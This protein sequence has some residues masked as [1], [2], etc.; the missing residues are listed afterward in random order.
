MLV[1]TKITKFTYQRYQIYLNEELAFVLYK[2]EVKRYDLEVGINISAERIK[3]IESEVLLPRSKKK[4]LHILERSDRSENELRQKLKSCFYPQ[5]IIDAT[6]MYVKSF[7]YIDDMN[8]C[9]KFIESRGNHKSKKDLQYTLLH[10]GVDRTLIDEVLSSL[11]TE[12]DSECAIEQLIR[13][14]RFDRETASL[15]E[16]RKLYAYLARKGFSYEEVSRVLPI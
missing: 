9:K 2:N 15:D 4:A 13:K 16:Y 12:E 11:Y 10:K 8:Y 14:R 6:I 3:Q 7:G 5:G 1:I